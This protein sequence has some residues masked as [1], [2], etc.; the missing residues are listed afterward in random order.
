MDN[1]KTNIFDFETLV[2]TNDVE[3]KKAAGRDGKGAIPDSVWET[4]S[5]MAN[6]E[7]G[8]IILGAEQI[9]DR[10]FKPYH[11]ATQ[12]NWCRISGIF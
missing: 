8:I 4:Y 9:S 10:E 12:K 6:T 11:L 1:Q 7:G 2:E 3:M 5:A